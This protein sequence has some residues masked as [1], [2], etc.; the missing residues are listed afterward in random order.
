MR[1]HVRL[2][3]GLGLILLS[4]TSCLTVLGGSFDQEVGVYSD[5]PGA[6][7]T[8][9]PRGDRQ[10]TPAIFAL[11]RDGAHTL[12]V[13]LEGYETATVFIERRRP[14]LRTL[15]S[16]LTGGIPGVAVDAMSGAHW[17]LWPDHADVTLRPIE[18][19]D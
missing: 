12:R 7:V 10:R 18:A 9:Y 17:I 3:I 19:S 14:A 4:S 5:P 6:W 13:E 15:V 1:R 2:S 16:L 11:E 8:L